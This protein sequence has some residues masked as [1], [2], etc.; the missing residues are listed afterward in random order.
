MQWI[1]LGGFF[2]E[3]WR[4]GINCIP[5]DHWLAA[6]R[7]HIATIRDAINLFNNSIRLGIMQCYGTTWYL[8]T[9]GLC[10]LGTPYPDWHY[11]DTATF[12]MLC[13]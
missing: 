11:H 13:L 3:L 2:L 8:E 9:G 5:G 10:S 7:Y 12:K 4:S 1:A 6:T